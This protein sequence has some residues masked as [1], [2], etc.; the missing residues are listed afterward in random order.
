MHGE[1]KYNLDDTEYSENKEK[2]AVS[3]HKQESYMLEA[4]TAQRI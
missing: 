3:S 4:K 2:H 1:K